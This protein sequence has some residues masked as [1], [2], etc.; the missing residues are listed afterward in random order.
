MLRPALGAIAIV[1][2]G[3]CIACASPAPPT[4]PRPVARISVRAQAGHLLAQRLC[5]RCHQVDAAGDSPN[6]ES[7]P[8]KVLA[9][10]YNEVTLGRKLDDI[11]IGHY[12]MPPTQVSNDDIDSLVAYLESFNDDWAKPER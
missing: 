10:R 4:S 8:F 3:A 12:R 2:L 6:P 11:A 7:P 1:A 5:S 9:A